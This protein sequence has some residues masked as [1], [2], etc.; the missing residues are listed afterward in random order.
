MKRNRRGKR[1]KNNHKFFESHFSYSGINVMT[2]VE[3]KKCDRK[4]CVRTDMR[5]IVVKKFQ[6][7]VNLAAAARM[8][9]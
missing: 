6:V 3:Q 1:K 5:I 2:R 8:K 7:Y 9:K 4:V